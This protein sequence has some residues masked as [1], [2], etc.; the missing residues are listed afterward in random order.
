MWCLCWHFTT[1][2]RYHC[3]TDPCCYVLLLQAYPCCVQMAV[4]FHFLFSCILSCICWVCACYIVVVWEGEFKN[5]C[6]SAKM[7]DSPYT[8]T[9]CML[10]PVNDR[11]TFSVINQAYLHRSCFFDIWGTSRLSV[12]SF[13]STKGIHANFCINGRVTKV[14]YSC[15][16][17]ALLVVWTYG[18]CWL[19]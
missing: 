12:H 8:M 15:M 11:N 17:Q 18:V 10:K 13:I 3:K 16:F 1:T 9:Y 14:I 5:K 2:V 6:M 4:C 19:S 7:S